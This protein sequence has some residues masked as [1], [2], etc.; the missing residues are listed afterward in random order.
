M[1]LGGLEAKAEKTGLDMQERVS[2]L[3]GKAKREAEK[4]AERKKNVRKV[5]EWGIDLTE[6]KYGPASGKEKPF[7]GGKHAQ[8]VHDV[9]MEIAK[10]EGLSE[11]E[12]EGVEMATGAHDVDTDLGLG[13]SEKES[14]RLLRG[15][16]HSLVFSVE[17]EDIASEVLLATCFVMEGPGIRQLVESGDDE[18]RVVVQRDGTQTVYRVGKMKKVTADSDL[19]ANGAPWEKYKEWSE[20]LG[21]EFKM[22]DDTMTDDKWIKFLQWQEKF[23]THRIGK[24]G[25][26][27]DGAKRV[28]PHMADNL[29][30]V[31]E[32]IDRL[33]G[34]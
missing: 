16:M 25:F 30:R 29:K 5:V 19:W 1:A 20:R 34:G 26:F 2:E 32:E 12:T 7:H 8:A 28:F 15:K 6:T 13:E 11:E 33:Q 31:K 17:E 3:N 22:I 9:G 10:E 24:G 21:R 4:I 14:A 27:T 18:V 23:L